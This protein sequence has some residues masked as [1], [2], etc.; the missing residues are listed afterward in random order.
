MRLIPHDRLTATPWKNGG[1]ETR[2]IAAFPAGAEYDDVAW[3]LSLATIATIADAAE[4]AFGR[5]YDSL[6][7]LLVNVLQR[8]NDKEFRRLRGKAMECATLIALAVGKERLGD[9]AMTLV[10]LLATIQQG[11]TTSGMPGY[12]HIPEDERLLIAK[13]VISLQGKP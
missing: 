12:G 10:Q 3:R 9:D 7:P 11:I 1:G 6:M 4:Q 13:Y 5:Y 2:E 8:E